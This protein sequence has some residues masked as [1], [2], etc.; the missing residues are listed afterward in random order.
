MNRLIHVAFEK[1]LAIAL[2][3]L[4]APFFIIAP[5]LIFLE[6]GWPAFYIGE[7]LGK[8]RKPFG[9][10]K[11]RTL[12]KG[13]EG[14][15]GGQLLNRNHQ[16]E[17]VVGKFL[18]ET[19]IDEIPQ[20]INVLKG[21]MHFFGPRPERKA[22]YELQCKLIPGYDKRFNIKP[23][24]FGFSQ[25]FTPHG[26]PKRLRALVDNIYLKKHQSFFED[27]S[28]VIYAL[29]RLGIYVVRRMME[30]IWNHSRLMFM[31]GNFKDYREMERLKS[32]RLTL[33]IAPDSAFDLNA[34]LSA[35]VIDINENYI[36][37]SSKV[38]IEDRPLALRLE[39]RGPPRSG[40]GAKC[41]CIR[42]RGRIFRSWHLHDY[43]ATVIQF[44]P[45][46]PFNQ[47]LMD[48]YVLRKSIF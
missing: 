13:A 35:R 8:D 40:K 1:L 34:P 31:T 2:L 38:P 16:L 39:W 15:V 3:I 48:K 12:V 26:T 47:Y 17:L 25:L 33:T 30:L 23:G 9:M 44:E 18:R 29:W 24:L 45:I 11:F 42:C 22:V 43:Y 7:R 20:L 37:V 10:I 6:D 4:N 19:R 36:L 14:R 32:E 46:S 27:L 21:D 5:L 41:K 28:V